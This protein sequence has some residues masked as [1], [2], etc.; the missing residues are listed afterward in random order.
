MKL[1]RL[2]NRLKMKKYPFVFLLG[3]MLTFSIEFCYA[4]EETDQG[5]SFSVS[6]FLYAAQV[7][8]DVKFNSAINGT[9]DD[10]FEAGGGVFLEA[11][12]KKWTF[13]SDFMFLGY[14]TGFTAPLS[15]R[16]GDYEGQFIVGSVFALYDVL[17]WLSLGIGGKITVLD[18][19]VIIPR[20]GLLPEVNESFKVWVFPPLIAYRIK[21][22]NKD[23][24]HAGVQGEYGGFGVYGMQS[25]FINPYLTYQMGS[26]L[27][28]GLSY[29]YLS[30]EQEDDNDKTMTD[31]NFSGPQLILGIHF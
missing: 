13:A 1:S 5:W 2:S 29:R 26:Y 30:I 16:V 24:L 8:G 28:L 22:I 7:K 6:P 17:P 19:E 11:S 20:Q 31:L 4:Q 10:Q 3:L 9:L 21:L 23:K 25:F 15:G 18:S 27:S 14:K 12:K